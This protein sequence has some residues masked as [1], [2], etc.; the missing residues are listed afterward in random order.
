MFPVDAATG[1]SKQR[2]DSTTTEPPRLLSAA[3]P[4]RIEMFEAPAP[5]DD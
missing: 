5:L 1:E 2:P 3:V 4:A